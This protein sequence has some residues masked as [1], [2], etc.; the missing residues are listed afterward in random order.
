MFIF[1]IPF[2]DFGAVKIIKMAYAILMLKCR[3]PNS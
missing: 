3:V 2:E 1:F